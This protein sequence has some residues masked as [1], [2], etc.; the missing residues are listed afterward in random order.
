MLQVPTIFSVLGSLLILSSTLMLG[1]FEKRKDKVV[2]EEKEELIRQESRQTTPRES[3]AGMQNGHFS[4]DPGQY[5]PPQDD[6][7][8]E[9]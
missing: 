7:T 2:E 9:R 3:S 6:E 1:V 4:Q 5:A 8:R